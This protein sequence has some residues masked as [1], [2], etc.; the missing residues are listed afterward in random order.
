MNGDG[1]SDVPLFDFNQIVNATS[2][3][4]SNYKLGQGGFGPVYKGVL[5]DGRQDKL[6]TASWVVCPWPGEVA[7]L[8]VHAK[9]ELLDFFIFDET[10][11][12]LLDWERRFE[13][14]EGIAQ[15]LVYLH[16]HSRL[17]I[18]HRD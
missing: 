6:S 8:R 18:V 4:S 13:I 7:C 3:F 5:R 2:N 15:G 1:S 12:A 11:A 16:K 14:I 17:R 10:R 9:Q